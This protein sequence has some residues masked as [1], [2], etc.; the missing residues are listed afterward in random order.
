[1]WPPF[2]YAWRAMGIKEIRSE[3]ERVDR[4]ILERVA[5]RQRLVRAVE[6]EKARLGRPIRDFTRERQIIER[7]RLLASEAGVDPTLAQR[8]LEL[9]IR[10]SLATQEKQRLSAAAEG[11][12]RRALVIGGGGRMGSWFARFL[13]SQGFSVEVADPSPEMGEV[14]FA[15]W[16]DS[17][18]EHE[19]IVVAAPLRATNEILEELVERRPPGVVFDI[20]SLKAPVAESLRRLATAG[21]D[22]TSVHPLFGPS[23]ELLSG[24]VVV[25]IDLGRPR[26]LASVKSLFASTMADRIEM[27]LDEHDRLMRWVLA[28][29]HATNITFFTALAASGESAERLASLASPT[30][31]HQLTM[32]GRVAGENP[33]LYYEIQALAETPGAAFEAL[34]RAASSLARIVA[35]GDEEVF[36][37]LMREGRRYL[38]AKNE[39]L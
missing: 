9:L 6:E 1:M 28:L 11:D 34:Q 22:V 16:R 35:E 38:A 2:A 25:F 5:E 27:T 15:D 8:L 17:D 36:V 3:L 10:S 14:D 26:A 39:G 37:S 4:E 21:V 18:L 12:G 33:H 19:L 24:R 32:A 23:A 13:T 30:F 29:S 31:D 20:G 7:I